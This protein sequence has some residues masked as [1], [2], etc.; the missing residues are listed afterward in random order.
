MKRKNIQKTKQ[1]NSL[2]D[3]LHPIMNY[4]ISIEN[5]PISD[6]ESNLV[7]TLGVPKNWIME[8]DLIYCTI[9]RETETLKLIKLEP[10]PDFEFKID[11]FYNYIVNL[12]NKNLLIDQKRV[13]LEEQITRLKNKFEVEQKELMDNLFNDEKNVETNETE[14]IID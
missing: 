10:I 1:G 2:F 3:L 11:D 4:L 6:T 14:E 8:T 9:I 5:E 12:I 7:F 13:E